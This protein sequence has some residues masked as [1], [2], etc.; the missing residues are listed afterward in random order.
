MN[1]KAW[2]DRVAGLVVDALLT[3]KI[4]KKE[5]FEKAVEIASEEINVRLCLQDLPP[6]ESDS[7]V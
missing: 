3:A 6:P 2:S 1:S 5:D 7:D 4:L